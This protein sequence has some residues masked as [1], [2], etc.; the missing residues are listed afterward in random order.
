MKAGGGSD[1]FPCEA[2]SS[3][4]GS[5]AEYREKGSCQPCKSHPETS[6]VESEMRPAMYS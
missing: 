4:G 6:A 2:H 5:R 3:G 1:V